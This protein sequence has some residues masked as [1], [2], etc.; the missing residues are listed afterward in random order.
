[1]LPVFL[2]APAD[3]VLSL[4][5][6]ALGVDVNGL[7]KNAS[8]VTVSHGVSVLRGLVTGYLVARLFPREA[9]GQYQFMLSAIGIAGVIGLPG[10]MS[11]LSRAIA[12]GQTGVVRGVL[13]WQLGMSLV[14]SCA[15]F[16]SIPFLDRWGREELWPLLV[17]AAVLLPLSQY[18]NMLFGSLTVGKARFDMALKANLTMSVLIVLSTL[19]ILFTYPNSASLLT[20]V[21]GIPALVYLAFGRR[22]LPPATS[23]PT[24]PVVRYGFELSLASLPMTLSWYLDKILISGMFGLNQLALFSAS[25][26]LPEQLKTWAK[27]LLPVSFAIQARGEDSWKRRGR[28][29]QVVGRS[30]LIL[31]PFIVAYVLAAPWLFPFLFPNYA[32]GVLLTQ[33][34]AVALC[35]QPSALLSQYL[36]AQALLKALRWTQWISAATFCISLLVLLPWLGLLGAVIARGLLRLSYLICNLVALSVIPPQPTQPQTAL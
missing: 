22:I 34:A 10:L 35:L 32:E 27:E 3:R 6:S 11:A 23:E 19:I 1:M 14:A 36:E 31:S 4:L 7:A 8:I 33:V 15:L 16:L 9:Y 21:I 30:T 24:R 25:I 12:R 20:T 13:R 17:L 28:L 18:G 26:L 2:R 5:R 29:L